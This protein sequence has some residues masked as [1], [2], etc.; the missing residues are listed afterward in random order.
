MR[1]TDGKGGAA[2]TGDATRPR[3]L[4]VV[5]R[6]KHDLYA[7][8]RETFESE[9]RVDVILDRRQADPGGERVPTEVDRSGQHRRRPLTAKQLDLWD[10][11]GFLLIHTG[12]DLQVYEAE[13]EPSGKTVPPRAPEG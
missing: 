2:V 11:S 6:D 10:N 3:W 9:T 12:E 7:N 8:L 13:D 5:R 1:E 4:I